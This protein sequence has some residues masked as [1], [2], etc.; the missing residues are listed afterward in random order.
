MAGKRVGRPKFTYNVRQHGIDGFAVFAQRITDYAARRFE[1]KIDVTKQRIKYY[2]S[3]DAVKFSKVKHSFPRR[4]R[5]QLSK[6][7]F[8]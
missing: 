5:F 4:T 3:D 8:L 2:P 7:S 6:V 1:V